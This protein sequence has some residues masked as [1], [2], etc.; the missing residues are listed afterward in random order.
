MQLNCI[1]A[2][3]ISM[4]PGHPEVWSHGVSWDDSSKLSGL[5][6][7]SALHF[8]WVWNPCAWVEV[9]KIDDMV[10]FAASHGSKVCSRDILHLD[11]DLDSDQPCPPLSSWLLS[12]PRSTCKRPTSRR[13]RI[14]W[15]GWFRTGSCHLTQIRLEKWRFLCWLSI[16]YCHCLHHQRQ[17]V[18]LS[19]DIDVPS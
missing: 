8:L 5:P 4:L 19:R 6:M 9:G 14:R 7:M 11:L 10:L 12:W 2:A 3:S 15:S 13:P 16:E 18:S 1:T 17:F